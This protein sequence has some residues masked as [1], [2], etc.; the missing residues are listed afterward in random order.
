M[1]PVWNVNTRHEEK[2]VKGKKKKSNN[3]SLTPMSVVPISYMNFPSAF[4]KE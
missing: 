2:E 4:T 1:F 3:T